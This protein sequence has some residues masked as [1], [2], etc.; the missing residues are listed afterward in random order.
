MI[1][2]HGNNFESPRLRPCWKI[3]TMQLGQNWVSTS[4]KYKFLA[5]FDIP[6]I[7]GFQN[8]LIHGKHFREKMF[9]SVPIK[10]RERRKRR[11]K[12]RTKKFKYL[13]FIL[14]FQNFFPA[15]AGKSFWK[16][17]LGSVT[18]QEESFWKCK[19]F[20]KKLRF[21]RENLVIFFSKE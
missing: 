15:F 2:Y 16:Q 13:L 9:F 1:L 7:R 17:K 18:Q 21:L 19:Q 20:I 14:T 8:E 11:S 3:W 5:L 6:A 10:S 4:R 12:R